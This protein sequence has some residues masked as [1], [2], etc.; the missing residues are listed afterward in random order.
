MRVE[1]ITDLIPWTALIA[2]VNSDPAFA[3]PN[4]PGQEEM[5]NKL[6]K[7]MEQQEEKVLGIYRDDKPEGLFVLLVSEEDRNIEA[8]VCLTRSGDVCEALVV[9][10]Q[11]KYP[12]FQVDF[13]FNPGNQPLKETLVRNGAAF[14]PEQ[15][16]MELTG[17]PVP[18]DTEGIELLSEAYYEQYCA[19][20]NKDMFWTG[21]KTAAEP[22]YFRVLV[23]AE[24]GRIAGYLDVS[25]PKEKNYIFDLLVAEESRRRGWGRKLLAKAIELNRPHGMA[26][27]V[28]VD[29]E[30]ARHLYETMGFARVEGKNKITA[31]IHLTMNNEQ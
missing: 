22:D 5:M 20:H 13:V 17:E 14:D 3:D 21:E 27:D 26:L 1:E 8:S 10:L 31:T 30:P 24:N 11:E 6:R 15:Q 23:A 2:D 29:N 19:L 18:A 7:S 12:G 25:W 16:Y 9:Y 28:N 4:H